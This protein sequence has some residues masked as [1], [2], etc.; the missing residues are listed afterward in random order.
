MRRFFCP[1]LCLPLLRNNYAEPSSGF[2]NLVRSSFMPCA[3]LL[4]SESLIEFLIADLR[5][6]CEIPR[7]SI[8]LRF[9]SLYGEGV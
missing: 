8:E 9:L 2:L 5:G 7:L 3:R 4:M 6:L 1:I